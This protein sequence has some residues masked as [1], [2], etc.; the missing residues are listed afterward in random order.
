M[1]EE[2][3]M[4]VT[5]W[6]NG[7]HSRKGVGYGIRISD[8]ERDVFFQR[9]W[10]AVLLQ[11]QGQEEAIEVKI[12]KDSFWGV[13]GRELISVEIGRWLRNQGLASWSRGNPPK[14][15]LEPLEDNRFSL[16]KMPKQGEGKKW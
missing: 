13:P 15:I 16:E 9:E 7:A 11:L 1:D 2:V 4:I 14:L 3:E 6:N 10:D 12:D 5:A 8:E